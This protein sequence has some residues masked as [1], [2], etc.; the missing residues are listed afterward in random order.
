MVRRKITGLYIHAGVPL[1]TFPGYFSAVT[2]HSTDKCNTPS[3]LHSTSAETSTDA[4]NT[5]SVLRDSTEL[6]A[7][8]SMNEKS[9]KYFILLGDSGAEAANNYLLIVLI[10]RIRIGVQNAAAGLTCARVVVGRRE[11]IVGHREPIVTRRKCLLSVSRNL[12]D[13]DRTILSCSLCTA[14]LEIHFHYLSRRPI[15]L[16]VLHDWEFVCSL[17]R[18]SV[19]LI[20]GEREQTYDS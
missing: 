16:V 19:K 10:R 3:V 15:I 8:I 14:V 7:E 2:Y 9:S 13:S 18:P 11:P 1:G 20:A 6:S 5:L 12:S 17:T 4:Y